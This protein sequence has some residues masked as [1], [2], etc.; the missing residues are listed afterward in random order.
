MILT[1]TLIL[2]LAAGLVVAAF[3]ADRQITAARR[4]ANLRDMLD[5]AKYAVDQHDRAELDRL[6]AEMAAN[7]W[8]GDDDYS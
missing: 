3:V 1:L 8:E 7:G 6:A 4:E 5:R 2:A